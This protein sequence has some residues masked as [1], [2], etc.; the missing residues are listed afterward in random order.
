MHVHKER[1]A[2][3]D[4]RELTRLSAA[5]AA[6]PAQLAS[7]PTALGERSGTPL[8]VVHEP[9]DSRSRD[10]PSGSHRR[11]LHRRERTRAPLAWESARVC[12]LAEHV[13]LACQH[14]KRVDLLALAG[15]RVQVRRGRRLGRLAH[16]ASVD[17]APDTGGLALYSAR[18]YTR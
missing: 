16:S 8:A 15:A 18:S 14:D 10:E 6:A 2:T 9:D 13:R 17:G 12:A 11:G 7:A 3:H 5:T 1:A 4:L